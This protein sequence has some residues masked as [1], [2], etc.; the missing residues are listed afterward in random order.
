MISKK[1]ETL[2]YESLNI[3]KL[4]IIDDSHKHQNHSQ[5]S[6]GHFNLT[7]VSDNFISKSLIERH[8][9]VYKILDKMIQK[10]IH[11]LSINAKT[12]DEYS[13]L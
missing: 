13:K 4:E 6:G 1:I 10:E 12:S 7:I 3:S 2:L 11:A 5:S 9:M 8:R